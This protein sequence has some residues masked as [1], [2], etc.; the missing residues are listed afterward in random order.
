MNGNEGMGL[1]GGSILAVST[2]GCEN[3]AKSHLVA[4][5][6]DSARYESLHPIFKKAF[7][8]L[9]R[10]D[11]TRLDVGRYEIDGS[12][13]WAMVQDAALVPFDDRKIEAHRKF[14]DIQAPISGPE[15]IGVCEMTPEQ[16]ALPF[17]EKDDYVLFNGK[18]TPVTLCPGEF[19]IFFPPYGAHAPGCR[20]EG[21]PDRIRKVVI[22]VRA[23]L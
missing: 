4:N 18:S 6:E 7:A 14:I 1:R 11:L 8:F 21:G 13:C 3:I 19:A 17:D 20:A 16:L 23:K 9:R 22:K 15:T 10:E 2:C 12:N 5:V